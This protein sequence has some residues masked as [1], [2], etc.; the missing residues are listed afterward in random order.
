MTVTKIVT[1]IPDALTTGPS[2]PT[3]ETGTSRELRAEV[4]QAEWGGF[5]LSSMRACSQAEKRA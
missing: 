3:T 1:D 2:V 5:F 4:S